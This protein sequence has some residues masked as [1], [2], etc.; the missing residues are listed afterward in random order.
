MTSTYCNNGCLKIFEDSIK[1]HNIKD[2]ET[3]LF[4]NSLKEVK[5]YVCTPFDY[6]NVLLSSLPHSTTI[7]MQTFN[8]G[9]CRGKKYHYLRTYAETGLI[10]ETFRRME[11]VVRSQHPIYSV[12]GRGPLAEEIC[13]HEGTTCWGNGTPFEKLIERNVLI[14]NFGR[15]FPW[16]I[17]LLHRFEEIKRVPYRYFK[18]FSGMTDFGDGEKYYETDMY[19]RDLNANIPYYWQMA[20][21]LLVEREQVRG[22]DF[23]F[24]LPVVRAKDLEQACYEC[25]DRDPEIFLLKDR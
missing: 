22:L 7:I 17:I 4:I 8:W 9:F 10:S 13:R 19:V 11:R 20:A 15:E 23:E 5:C 18:T 6:I 25:L 2:N 12:S 21:D 14:M 24:Q 3:I 1:S 16:G